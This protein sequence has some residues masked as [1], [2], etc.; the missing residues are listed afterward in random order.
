MVRGKARANPNIV[1]NESATI[2]DLNYELYI[3]YLNY[4]KAK[5]CKMKTPADL[6]PG[7]E[8]APETQT[9][10]TKMITSVN[11]TSDSM[12]ARPRISASWIPGRAAGLRAMPSQAEDATRD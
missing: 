6:R 9:T 1:L 8:P 12:N 5:R 7:S 4:R 3:Y 2:S 10:F 11:N